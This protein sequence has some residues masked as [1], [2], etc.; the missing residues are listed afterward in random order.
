MLACSALS[1]LSLP[2]SL[3]LPLLNSVHTLIHSS[4]YNT[5]NT[6]QMCVVDHPVYSL[7]RSLGP[8]SRLQRLI[9][10][11]VLTHLQQ[12]NT[13]MSTTVE[14]TS[15]TPAP[16][17]AESTAPVVA[18]TETA[19]VADEAAKVGYTALHRLIV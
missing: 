13:T 4:T 6:R 8:S 3:R 17:V 10:T 15:T 7:S 9:L 18:Q 5:S 14:G 1:A 11:L 12:H 19:P 16:V 2:N